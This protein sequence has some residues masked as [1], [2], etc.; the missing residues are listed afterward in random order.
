MVHKMWITWNAVV[1]ERDDNGRLTKEKKET[2][3]AIQ[4]QFELEY[5][6]LRPQDWHLMEMGQE[7]VLYKMA[8]EQR[9]W[10]RVGNRLSA[11]DRSVRVLGLSVE[12]PPEQHK[13]RTQVTLSTLFTVSY[14]VYEEDEVVDW[15][16]LRAVSAFGWPPKLSFSSRTRFWHSTHKKVANIQKTSVT[17]NRK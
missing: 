16:A 8:N 14:Y 3:E 12:F 1:N 17:S 13:K 4:D 9:A 2:E 6:D 11:Y 7:T 15:S 5:E 10:L